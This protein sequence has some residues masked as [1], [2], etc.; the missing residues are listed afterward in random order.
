FPIREESHKRSKTAVESSTREPVDMGT[1]TAARISGPRADRDRPRALR[2]A[3]TAAILRKNAELIDLL[4][5][6]DYDRDKAEIE[7]T[8]TIF[9]NL[10]NSAWA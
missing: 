7:E 2:D 9:A 10:S 4:G 1:G 3:L 5:S 8:V 6:P